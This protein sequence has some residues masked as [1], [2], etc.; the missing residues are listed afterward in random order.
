MNLHVDPIVFNG[1]PLTFDTLAR[2]GVRAARVAADPAAL[3]R[4]RQSRAV[5]EARIEGGL[6]VYG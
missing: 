5:V 4:V 3:D 1:K 2:V 6:P